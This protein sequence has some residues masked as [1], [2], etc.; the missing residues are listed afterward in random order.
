[1]HENRQSDILCV[2]IW[3]P[4]CVW[5]FNKY[6][7]FFHLGELTGLRGPE[8][9]QELSNQ[10]KPVSLI[11]HPERNKTTDLTKLI[12][13]IQAIHMVSKTKIKWLHCGHN[14]H[15][16]KNET[17]LEWQC[18]TRPAV[19]GRL[20]FFLKILLLKDRKMSNKRSHWASEST[21][22]CSCE[23]VFVTLH[24]C[25]FSVHLNRREIRPSAETPAEHRT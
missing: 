17:C 15:M 4:S 25:V 22:L 18:N 14:N 5:L 3:F 13:V 19:D 11:S 12:K 16:R 9:M 20:D 8:V 24:M 10:V 6:K 1:M 2:T 7:H 21:D 23:F